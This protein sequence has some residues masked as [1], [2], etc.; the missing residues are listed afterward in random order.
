MDTNTAQAPGSLVCRCGACRI[1]VCDPTLRYRIE[2]LCC[3]CRQRLLNSAHRRIGNK[4]P[5]AIAAYGRGVDLLYFANALRV[6]DDSH[7]LLEFSKLREDA[8]NTTAMSTCCGTV[9]CGAHPAFE[10][11]AIWATPDSCTV[12]ARLSMSPQFYLFSC[13]FPADKY[14]SL[15]M[16]HTIPTVI[17]ASDKIDSPPLVELLTAVRAPLAATYADNRHTTFE[18]LCASRPIEIDNACYEESRIGKPS[19]GEAASF[20][21][22]VA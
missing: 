2:C 4:V 19:T 9:M 12:N 21:V 16:Q 17:C 18:Q 15:P 10:G 8:F 1:A 6:D 5:S 13:D 3:D 14:A 22:Q 11:A 7:A 20:S